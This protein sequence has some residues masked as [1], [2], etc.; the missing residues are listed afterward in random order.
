MTSTLSTL[1]FVVATKPSTYSSK[2]TNETRRAKL[3]AA[4]NEQVKMI[5]GEITGR[6]YT[7]NKTKKDKAGN[8]TTTA[9]KMKKW[10]WLDST[11]AVYAEIHYGPSTLKLSDDG[12]SAFKAASLAA[13]VKSLN[14]VQTAVNSG[15]LDT[16]IATAAVSRRKKA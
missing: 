13:M 6:P 12:K 8:I 10:Y 7:A 5:N 11:G 16:L 3:V 2:P 14:L 9:K 15:E 1:K 4:I